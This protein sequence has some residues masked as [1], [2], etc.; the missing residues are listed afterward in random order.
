MQKELL[1]TLL[2]FQLEMQGGIFH[3]CCSFTVTWKKRQ[4]IQ[5]LKEDK[6]I[7]DYLINLFFFP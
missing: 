7:T 2:F 4:N 3:S 6:P 5:H 1:L